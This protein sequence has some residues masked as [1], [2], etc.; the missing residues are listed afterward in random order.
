MSDPLAEI[1]NM[2]MPRA[3]FTKV[4]HA[5]GPWRVERTEVGKV[6]YCMLLKGRTCLE[7]DGADAVNL[8]AG[9]FV[10]VPAAANYALS[11]LDP[12]CTTPLKDAP[13]MGADGVVRIGPTEE[14]ATVQMLIGYC[15]LG[16]PDAALLVSLL[17]E[18]VV[19][20]SAARLSALSKLVADEARSERPG[21]EVVLEHLLQ[22]MMIEALRSS[23][24]TTEAPGL[25]KGLA[26]ERL[27]PSLR[28]V[29]TAPSNSWTVADMAQL[30]G[31]SRSA[32]FARFNR[33]VG[34]PPMDYLQ[35]WR[36]TIAKDLL[37]RGHKNVA[38]VASEVGY[39]SASAFSIAFSRQ[40]GQPPGH[41]ARRNGQNLAPSNNAE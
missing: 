13:V 30:A 29:H 37:R 36:M 26:D 2:L 33:N 18:M 35:G 1:I 41:Y 7:V 11:S 19:V 6:F 20:R 24:E 8:C 32:Y 10:L 34:I 22:V 14:P 3:P 5:S 27:A 4:A 9:D 25:L 21:R 38:Q 23:P 28:A 39:G 15:S 12:P 17:P 40:T 31:L 16:S